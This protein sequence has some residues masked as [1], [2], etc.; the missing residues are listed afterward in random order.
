MKRA[1]AAHIQQQVN[2]NTELTEAQRRNINAQVENIVGS[3]TFEKGTDLDAFSDQLAGALT[4]LYTFESDNVEETIKHYSDVISKYS[5]VADDLKNQFSDF[6]NVLALNLND[7]GYDAVSTLG[8]TP[9]EITK[10]KNAFVEAG[11]TEDDFNSQLQQILN[12]GGSVE[13]LA[14]HFMQLG[15]DL[16]TDKVQAFKNKLLEL[17]GQDVQSTLENLTRA[18]S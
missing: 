5:G 18:T 1:V 8:L 17:G 4:E 14:N 7:K 10:L 9:E 16:P 13:D 6:E 15:N 11:G 3:K 12:S 2:A